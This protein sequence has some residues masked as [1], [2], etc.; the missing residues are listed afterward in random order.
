MPFCSNCG[1]QLTIGIENFCPNCGQNLKWG[2]A[3]TSTT[4][5]NIT[6]S[7]NIQ[8]THGD[9][10]GVGVKGSGIL[11]YRIII[12]IRALCLRNFPSHLRRP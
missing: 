6:D 12:S 9:V 7:I 1:Q 5:H 8:D 11:G 10:F 4:S 3:I 2:G